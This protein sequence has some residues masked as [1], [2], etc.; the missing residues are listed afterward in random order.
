MMPQ[1]MQPQV[2]QYQGGGPMM[3]HYRPEMMP[4]MMQ[5]PVMP[6]AMQYSPQQEGKV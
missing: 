1:G 5:R 3:M 2:Y 4:G 6:D